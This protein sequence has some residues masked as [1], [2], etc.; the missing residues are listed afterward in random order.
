MDA[1]PPHERT[2]ERRDLP[3]ALGGR[4]PPLLAAEEE[5]DLARRWIERRDRAALDRLVTSHLRLVRKM[6]RG[7]RGYGLALPDLVSAGTIGLIMAAYRFD[8][9]RGARFAT[10]GSFWIR[11]ELKRFVIDN[12]SLVRLSKRS[13]NRRVFFNL[14]RLK[15]ELGIYEDGELAPAAARRIARSLGVTERMVAEMN[16]RMGG[17]DV[18]LNGAIDESD[19]EWQDLLVRVE[20]DPESI[21]AAKEERQKRGTALRL[22]LDNLNDRERTIVAARCLGDERTTLDALAARLGVSRERVRQI[23]ARG[24]EKLRAELAAA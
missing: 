21:F 24:I 9:A 14:R 13:A 11:A 1:Q 3:S 15:S 16:E 22:A 20:D 23:E 10:Y 12:W 18:S 17:H 8:P 7:F 4:E 2:A 6:A 19:D 5:R